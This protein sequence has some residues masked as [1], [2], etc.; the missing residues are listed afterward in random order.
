M[1][2]PTFNRKS[3]HIGSCQACGREQ[4]LP[5]DVLSKH[6][7]HVRWS[8]FVGECPGCGH[9]PYEQ[10][11]SL[12]QKFIEDAKER[13]A[14]VKANITATLVPATE[15]KCWYHEYVGS[16]M[17]MG[18]Y[19]WRQID[20]IAKPRTVNYGAKYGGECTIYDLTY[21]NHEGKEERHP[22]GTTDDP[23]RTATE[24]NAK[25]V[26]WELQPHRKQLES[27]IKWQK[28]RVA[29]WKLTDLK[30]V[31]PEPPKDPNRKPRGY[32]RRWS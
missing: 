24:E 11:C 17:V 32:R 12:I 30:P 6:G 10:D 7:Y 27:Y 4:K 22:V 14:G 28:E 8:M 5:G 2:K 19:M 25:Y 3:T 29:N 15:P 23:L 21:T 9:K 20:L 1:P 13:L 18:R 16:F 26:E 31:P